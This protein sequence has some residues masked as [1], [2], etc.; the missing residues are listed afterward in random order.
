VADSYYNFVE[1]QIELGLIFGPFPTK[2]KKDSRLLSRFSKL[3]E[4]NIRLFKRGDREA[5][6][7]ESP[8]LGTSPTSNNA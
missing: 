8:E 3:I 5:D 2:R 7:R 1:G 6:F 4:N